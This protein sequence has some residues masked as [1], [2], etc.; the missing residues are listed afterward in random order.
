LKLK[1]ERR[2]IKSYL[3][4]N[5]LDAINGVYYLELNQEEIYERNFS[6][7]VYNDSKRFEQL[8]PTILSFYNTDKNIFKKH[9]VIKKPTYLYLKGR[10]LF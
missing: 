10:E 6:V 2:S 7:K 8:K 9:N 1:E 4:A 5:F 3:T